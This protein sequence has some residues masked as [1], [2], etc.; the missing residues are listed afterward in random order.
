MPSVDFR[1]DVLRW[2]RLDGN[3]QMAHLRRP[4]SALPSRIRS[5]GRVESEGQTARAS[6]SGM[7]RWSPVALAILLRQCRCSAFDARSVNAKGPSTGRAL[8]LMSLASLGNQMD[9]S[10]RAIPAHII[11]SDCSSFVLIKVPPMTSREARVADH[12][13]SGSR[14]H[15]FPCPPGSASDQWCPRPRLPVGA[16]CPRSATSAFLMQR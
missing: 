8:R 4:A 14:R 16:A 1:R 5:A 10:R 6:A 15:C 2:S 7:P 11:D 3:Q 9:S 12:I 13:S